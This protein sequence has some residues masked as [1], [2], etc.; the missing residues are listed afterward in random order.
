LGL[1]PREEAVALEQ[2]DPRTRGSL[3]HAVQ[4]V[5]LS[6][7]KA[8]GLLP[9]N[10]QRLPEVTVRADAVLNRVAAEY[11][12]RLAPAILRVWTSEI[13]DLRTDLRGWLQ[14]AARDDQEWEPV[15]FEFAFGLHRDVSPPGRDLH[16]AVPSD[17]SRDRQEAVT[18]LPGLQLKGAIDLIEKHTSR[19]VYRITDHKTGKAPEKPPLWV[20]GG[21]ALQP[22][23]YGLAVEKILGVT[24]E[25]GRLFYATQRGG[26]AQMAVN[27][28]DRARA[29]LAKF[30]AEIDLSISGG[31]LPPYP[32][33]D[34][35]G[36]CDY[37]PVCGP[38]EERRVA[39]KNRRDE[40]LEPLIAIRG[41]A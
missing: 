27:I 11:Q 30:Q 34:A 15:H 13:E 19:G 41:M 24:V 29:A 31:F 20:G 4:F 21:K 18:F 26:Y 12:E 37:R 23:L 9:L 35:C 25:S 22:L 8:A 40:R 2:L 36:F 7:L 1:H 33:K 5:L 32:E 39:R 14:H 6:E 10:P 16:G 28:N 38:Y 3:F 17:Q